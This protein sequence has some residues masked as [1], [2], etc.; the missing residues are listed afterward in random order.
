MQAELS[1]L[2]MEETLFFKHIWTIWPS[3]H[4]TATRKMTT[5][6]DLLLLDVGKCMDERSFF[7]LFRRI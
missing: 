7:V 5:I 3:A 4:V 2:C 6:R 1:V